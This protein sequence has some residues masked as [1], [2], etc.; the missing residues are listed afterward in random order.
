MSTY[1]VAGLIVTVVA[2]VCLATAQSS[3]LPASSG[4]SSPDPL[5]AS[6]K[7]LTP[8]SAMPAPHKPSGAMQNTS[9]SSTNTTAE[10]VRLEQ[11]PNKAAASKSGTTAP[12]K[13]ISIAKSTK[14]TGTSDGKNSGINFNYQKP[15]GGPQATPPGARSANSSKPRVKKN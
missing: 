4:K 13:P 3:Q 2:A 10:L 12:A 11:P 7:P 5:H 8:K 9:K 1:R 15:A 6:T 14:S